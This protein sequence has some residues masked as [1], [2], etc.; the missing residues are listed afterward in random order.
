MARTTLCQAMYE[1]AE[2]EGQ[3]TMT[4]GETME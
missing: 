1:F 3:R 2:L 4:S